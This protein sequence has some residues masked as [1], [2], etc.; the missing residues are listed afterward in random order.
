[1]DKVTTTLAPTTV[2][3]PRIP[4]YSYLPHRTYLVLQQQQ[5][6]IYL[7]HRACLLSTATTTIYLPA[8]QGRGFMRV[9]YVELG[10]TR[11]AEAVWQ[12]GKRMM[13]IGLSGR[14]RWQGGWWVWWAM[15]HSGR[16]VLL[17]HVRAEWRAQCSRKPLGTKRD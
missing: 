8:A 14:G 2:Y 5:L 6:K 9:L 7:S 12:E 15:V 13:W 1:M 17:K 4:P 11:K 10:C 16:E 3:L